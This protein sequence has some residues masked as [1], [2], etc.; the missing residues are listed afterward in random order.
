MKHRKLVIFILS[1]T[2][3]AQ[4]GECK[5]DNFDNLK[6]TVHRIIETGI[7]TGWDDKL[8]SR[9]GDMTALAIVKALPD[10]E[11][12][13]PNTI[14]SVLDVLY[15]SFSCVFRCVES[16]S[17]REPRLTLLLLD[18]LREHASGQL[19]TRVE[20]TTKFV[21]QQTYKVRLDTHVK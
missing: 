21:L 18:H 19:R 7:T 12:T 4:A 6:R 16:A 20:E 17:D 10:A 2:V 1:C 15:G 3:A 8:L 13:K 5:S 14:P 11:L 9:S